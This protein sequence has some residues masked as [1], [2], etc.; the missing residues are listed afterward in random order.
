M[1]TLKKTQKHG[2]CAAMRCKEVAADLLC[3]KHH[4]EWQEAG[5]PPLSAEPL[6]AIGALASPL[7]Q[8]RMDQEREKASRCLAMIVHLPSNTQAELDKLGM[9]VNSCKAVIDQLEEERKQQVQPLYDAV[10]TINGWARPPIEFYT[11]AMKA[12]KSKIATAMDALAK[13]RTEA[14]A[15]IASGAGEAPAEAFAIAHAPVTGPST[16][17]MRERVT[18]AVEDQTQVP[19]EYWTRT[20]N[21]KMIE[22][23]VRNGVTIPGVKRIVETQVAAKS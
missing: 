14:L 10:K 4:L 13:A 18:Y 9:L 15:Q 1:F 3:A 11:S 17:Q 12:L 6:A 21:Y 19:D 22:Q 20:L 2:T 23:A 5:S 7:F 16:V 8:Q